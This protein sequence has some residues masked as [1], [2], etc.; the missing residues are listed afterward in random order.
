MTAISKS[1]GAFS[2][3]VSFQPPLRVDERAD[4]FQ[5][6]TVLA[7]DQLK[8]LYTSIAKPFSLYPPGQVPL[9]TGKSSI[10]FPSPDQKSA[11]KISTAIPA[12]RSAVT[13][14]YKRLQALKDSPYVVRVQEIFPYP[15][16]KQVVL[17][18]ER[19]PESKLQYKTFNW[20]DLRRFSFHML[21]ALADLK[22]KKIVHGDLCKQNMCWN[23]E[24][25]NPP[26]RLFDF[27]ASLFEDKQQLKVIQ[28]T[29]YRSP[30]VF[31]DLRPYSCAADMWNFALLLFELYT[32]NMLL[33]LPHEKDHF[34]LMAYHVLGPPPEELIK[35]SKFL[36]ARFPKN[37]RGEIGYR[38]EFGQTFPHD[39][40]YIER[41]TNC[42]N[43]EQKKLFISFI[44][45]LL[46]WDP[47]QRPTPEEALKHPFLESQG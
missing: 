15:Q 18:L 34:C 12:A 42:Y 27:G 46:I 36:A 6:R 47:A 38:G 13:R 25:L 19:L 10:V 37:D 4:R 2:K 31:L 40:N 39:P 5:S 11:W 1:Q 20:D 21:K 28:R 23:P 30:E 43:P 9:G 32:G 33:G 14:E 35:K 7:T 8:N 41:H 45:S 44:R 17:I 3:P 29:P 16:T 22:E 26:L 24:L